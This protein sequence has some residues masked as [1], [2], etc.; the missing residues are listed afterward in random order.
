MLLAG[1][2]SSWAD[3]VRAWLPRLLTSGDFYS[4]S[5]LRVMAKERTKC[6]QRHYIPD[7]GKPCMTQ[8]YCMLSSIRHRCNCAMSLAEFQDT[9]NLHATQKTCWGTKRRQKERFQI[10]S[11]LLSDVLLFHEW[12]VTGSRETLI[13]ENMKQIQ[14]KIL[15][16]KKWRESQ[17]KKKENNSEILEWL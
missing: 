14:V 12:N 4:T 5:Q 9:L 16:G 11:T 10:S 17:W 2:P 1:A 7:M 13:I 8:P 3:L 15:D 6:R